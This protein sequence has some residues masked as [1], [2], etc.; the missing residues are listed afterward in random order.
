MKVLFIG[1]TGVISN[2]CSDL[3][4][5][6][7]MDLTILNRS[8]SKKHSIPA[9]AS[10]LI[11]D[12]HGD[13]A[14]LAELL[15]GQH[16]DVVVD[17]IAFTPDDIERDI[18]LLSG[19]TDQFVFISS[20]SAY[21]KPPAHYITTEETPLENPFW[22]YS[23]DKIACE[24][25]LMDEYRQN[26]FPVTI[27]RPSLTYGLSQIPLIMGSWQ[28][29]YTVVDRIKRGEKVIVPGD[30]SSL[31]VLTW[32]G[33]FA[34][35]LLGLFGQKDAIGE[36]FHI[37]SDEV[38]TWDQIYKELG[39]AIG[40]E[41]KIIHIPSDLIA[42]YSERAVGSLIGDKSNSAVFDNSKIKRFVPEFVCEVPWADGVRRALA[43]HEA[44]PARQEIDV[45]A[46]LLWDRIIAA[47]ER[48]F[49]V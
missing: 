35:G 42:M 1:G 37:T 13:P 8:A 27:I 21:Q 48:A 28:F 39:R 46:N 5:K 16:F 24:Q 9:G 31:W 49:P 45:E 4:I 43:W 36:A 2:G 47:Y 33:D 22:Q 26:G 6:R 44:D 15:H 32:N 10:L 7:G 23:R 30:G 20:A 12:V 3:A 34:K 25:R 18:R 41:P 19:K 29:P 14:R 40:V 38:L 17:W 11:G